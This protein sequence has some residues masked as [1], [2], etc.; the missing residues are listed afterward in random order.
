MLVETSGLQ[1]RVIHLR[2][3]AGQSS[4]QFVDADA[5][6]VLWALDFQCNSTI[7]GMVV[8]IASMINETPH[9]GRQRNS[10]L[11]EDQPTHA[12]R[13]R[14]RHIQDTGIKSCR[15]PTRTA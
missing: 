1:V 11:S 15:D 6:K 13:P 3:R 7:D 8:K 14:G 9:S 2:K 10:P 5:P 12:A 4:A